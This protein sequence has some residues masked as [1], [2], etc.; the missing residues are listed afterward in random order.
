MHY[1]LHVCCKLHL[2][3]LRHQSAI[4]IF[5]CISILQR[6]AAR[7]DKNSLVISQSFVYSS[8]WGPLIKDHSEMEIEGR[9]VEC[10]LIVKLKVEINQIIAYFLAYITL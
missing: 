6:T 4:N 10:N 8:V 7:V 1:N 2:F 5:D 9:S 3:L